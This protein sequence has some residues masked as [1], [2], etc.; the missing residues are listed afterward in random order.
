MKPPLTVGALLAKVVVK[1]LA[2]ASAIA[3]LA[4]NAWLSYNTL[5]A[6]A[7]AHQD[8]PSSMTAPGRSTSAEIPFGMQW[9]EPAPTEGDDE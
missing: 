5:K 1:D 3:A 4:Y 9:H 6:T 7:H 8:E 2:Y